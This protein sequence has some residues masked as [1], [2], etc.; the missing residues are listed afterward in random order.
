MT[1]KKAYKDY[2]NYEEFL[3]DHLTDRTLAMAYLQEASQDA[4]P[5]VFLI[6][7]KDVCDAQDLD[8]STIAKKAHVIPNA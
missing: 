3:R 7:L 1:K 4:D 6:A 2:V 8:V 5:N